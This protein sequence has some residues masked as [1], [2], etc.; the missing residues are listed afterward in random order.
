M[1]RNPPGSD[2]STVNHECDGAS[3]FVEANLDGPFEW[4]PDQTEG[5]VAVSADRK[6]AATPQAGDMV[7]SVRAGRS[8]IQ[9]GGI[10]RDHSR[11]SCR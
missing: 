4:P 11:S 7:G 2:L 6:L 10:G 5:L 1:R 3:D 9:T 8:L